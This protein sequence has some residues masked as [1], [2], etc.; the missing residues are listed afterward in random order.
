MGRADTLRREQRVCQIPSLQRALCA[1]AKS[2]T[3][4]ARR[5]LGA[6]KTLAK[7]QA[8]A[9]CA[10]ASSAPHSS[11]LACYQIRGPFDHFEP[12]VTSEEPVGNRFPR[13]AD[14]E[15]R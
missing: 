2:G 8:S 10:Q 14:L 9:A 5:A 6:C 1:M 12:C 13:R 11:R 3:G 15:H 7:Q 4:M